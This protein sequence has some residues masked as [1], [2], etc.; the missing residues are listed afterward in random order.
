MRLDQNG[1]IV[2][3]NQDVRYVVQTGQ[4]CPD[5]GPS[6]MLGPI[7]VDVDERG[8]GNTG[9]VWISLSICGLR[10]F[11][12]FDRTLVPRIGCGLGAGWSGPSSNEHFCPR[13]GCGGACPIRICTPGCTNLSQPFQTPWVRGNGSRDYKL[14]MS[15]CCS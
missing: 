15:P 9:R 13:S 8:P 4:N 14:L 6:D 10:I 7:N 1:L 11:D 5:Y 3:G 2:G 12:A